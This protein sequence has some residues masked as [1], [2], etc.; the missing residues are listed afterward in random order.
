MLFWPLQWYY[1]IR[2][3]KICQCSNNTWKCEQWFMKDLVQK[4]KILVL[5][6]HLSCLFNYIIGICSCRNIFSYA[7]QIHD[8]LIIG[9][10]LQKLIWN[11]ISSY[12]V[13]TTWIMFYVFMLMFL[14]VIRHRFP[15]SKSLASIA[16][17]RYG[18]HSLK[19]TRKYEKLDY[20]TGN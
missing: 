18:I 17:S 1:F 2:I 12:D 16:R 19:I 4:F 14:F 5:L 3:C 15:K 8:H 7:I 13:N 6:D 11:F 9:L 20:R 10:T